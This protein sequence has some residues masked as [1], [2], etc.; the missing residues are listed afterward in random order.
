MAALTVFVF[1]QTRLLNKLTKGTKKKDLKKILDEILKSQK[2]NKKGLKEV[3]RELQKLEDEGFLHVQKVG[4]VRFNPFREIGG[5]H[6]FSLAILD[7]KDNGVVIT[8]LHTRER[9]RIYAKTIKKSKSKLELSEE[10]EKALK[11][12]QKG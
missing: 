2:G 10:E 1:F 9:T 8:G 12:A 7:G 6:S 5:D 3:K 4:L 11:R